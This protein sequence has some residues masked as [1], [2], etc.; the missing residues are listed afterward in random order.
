MKQLLDYLVVLQQVPKGVVICMMISS[1]LHFMTLAK[2][3]GILFDCTTNRYHRPG[4]G[5]L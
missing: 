4:Y 1:N 3:Y 5:S 2:E